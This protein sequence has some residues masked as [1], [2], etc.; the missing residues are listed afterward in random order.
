[1]ALPNSKHRVT[2]RRLSTIMD[3]LWTKIRNKFKTKVDKVPGKGLSTNDFTNGYKS[4]LDTLDSKLAKK[5]DKTTAWTAGQLTVFDN[6]GCLVNAGKTPSDI[7]TVTQAQGKADKVIGATNGHLAGLDSSGNLT[8]AGITI[9]Q[10]D[11]DNWNAMEHLG[12]FKIVPLTQTEPYVPDVQ[13]PDNTLIYLTK[14]EGSGKTDPYTEW[15]YVTDPEQGEDNWQIIGETSID[16]DDY[17]TKDEADGRFATAAQGAKADTAYQKP[18]GGIP[19]ADLV[20]G[21]Q[22]SLDA[23]D[24]A[25]QLP[26]AGIPYGDLD[27][28]VKASLD[29]AD[30]AVQDSDYVHTD[31]NFDDNYKDKV[32]GV[33]A[34]A[35]VNAIEEIQVNGTTVSPVNKVVDITVPSQQNAD[36]EATSGPAEILNKPDLS[37]YYETPANGIPKTDLAQGVQDSLDLADS[38][39]QL[40]STGVPK[41]DL[42][43]GVQD[44]LDLADSSY[45]KPSGGIPKSDLVQGVQDSLDRADSAVQ[46]ASYVH[47]DNNYTTAEKTKL[48]GIEN[49]AQEN[50]IEE[51]QVNGAAVSPVNKSVNIVVPA[52]AQSNWEETDSSDPAYIQNKPDLTVYYQKP[53]TGIPYN[54]LASTV[55][56]SLDKADTAIQEHQDIS[57]KADKVSGATAGNLAALDANGNLVDSTVVAANTVQDA[58]YVHTDNNYTTAEKNKLS[59]IE[60]NAEVNIIETIKVNGTALVPD[61]DRA[62]D[63]TVPAAGDGKLK[64]KLGSASV[65]ETGFTANA[66]T[67]TTVEIPNATASV[68]GLMSKEDKALVHTHANQ[69]VLDDTTAPYTTAE[70]TK[71]SG[72]E[73]GAQVNII[74]SISVNGTAVSPDASKNV[75]L[76]VPVASDSSPAMDGTA[77]AGVSDDYSRADHVHPSDTSKQDVLQF[78]GTYDASTN[79]VATVSTVT[80]AV[81]DKVTKPSTAVTGDLVCFDANKDLVDAGK[82]INDFVM[83]VSYDGSAKKFT[84]T[85]TSGTS[86]IVTDA[87]LKEDMGLSCF[88]EMGDSYIAVGKYAVLKTEVDTAGYY[89]VD[90]DTFANDSCPTP[91]SIRICVYSNGSPLTAGTTNKFTAVV[92]KSGNTYIEPKVLVEETDATHY[93][94]YVALYDNQGNLTNPEGLWCIRRDTQY[95]TDTIEHTLYATYTLTSATVCNWDTEDIVDTGDI[96]DVTGKADKV[97]PAAANNFAALNSSGNLADSGYSSSSFAT[98]AQGATADSAVQGVKLGTTELTKDANNKVT[99]PI[100]STTDTGVT[101][102]QDSI[103]NTTTTAVTPHAVKYA[104]DELETKVNAR[105]VFMTAQEWETQSQQPGDPSKVYYVAV[106]SGTDKYDVYVWKTATNTYELVDQATISLDGYWHNGPTQSGSGNVVT[107]ITLGADGVPVVTKSNFV[108]VPTPTV[109]NSVLFF[110]GTNISWVT[111]GSHTFN[112]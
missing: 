74:E 88:H 4:K 28:G 12:G 26:L 54:D 46:D 98:A 108:V 11:I 42:A 91:E 24:S 111:L 35:Q 13:N 21:V 84:K 27:S 1:M 23:A 95:N 78:D 3:T 86:D 17:Y 8:D 65:T 109:A 29:L 99:I 71:L 82:S 81:A 7:F 15:I 103:D 10:Q 53:S 37:I 58:S 102:L 49:G 63:I 6:N 14:E 47:T 51:I 43:Q 36:W 22:D 106:G 57:G 107:D 56:A 90:I 25:Y 31:N 85:D 18:S 104:I 16:L 45:Q 61:S 76:T 93:T 69:Q 2:A 112:D 66:S 50:V 96:A 83:D 97:V 62:V 68:D 44:S 32:D 72:I 60:D 77:S 100:A 39:Y 59:G 67:D 110:D 75:A 20:Q 92:T 64:I 5:M 55:Q 105:A 94:L 52:Q 79:K 9:T 89:S 70:Q 40:P 38:S 101:T 41:T 34:G 73:T 30:S 80:D 87:A 33:A 48:S 19:K